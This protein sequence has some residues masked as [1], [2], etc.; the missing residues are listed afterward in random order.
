MVT[1][2]TASFLEIFSNQ[3]LPR[4]RQCAGVPT[5]RYSRRALR[6]P[7]QR[8][9]PPGVRQ[10]GLSTPPPGLGWLPIYA[11]SMIRH[12]AHHAGAASV[13]AS[14]VDSSAASDA[15]EQAYA[16]SR[17][18]YTLGCSH[19]GSAPGDYTMR[20]SHPGR[21]PKTSELSTSAYNVTCNHQ[22]H[23][24]G[25]KA[26]TFTDVAEMVE[27]KTIGKGVDRTVWCC[28][29]IGTEP[30]GAAQHRQP[31]DGEEGINSE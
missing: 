13:C 22:W 15:A 19:P 23:G 5:F 6:S 26:L 27:K 11:R 16:V 7:A 30:K 10:G 28:Y 21:G 29:D 24:I 4:V 12:H 25:V 1:R 9:G 2:Q 3:K 8:I 17:P 18:R 31:T 20:C 14:C